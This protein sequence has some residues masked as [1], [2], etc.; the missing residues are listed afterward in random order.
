MNQKEVSNQMVKTV[1]AEDLLR[2]KAEALVE[3][4]KNKPQS[5]KANSEMRKDAL[6]RKIAVVKKVNKTS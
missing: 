4:E 5:K 1:Q 3:Q 6:K 2:L